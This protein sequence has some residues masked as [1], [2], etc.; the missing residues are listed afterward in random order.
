MSAFGIYGSRVWRVFRLVEE[1]FSVCVPKV[2]IAFETRL[3]TGERYFYVYV[4]H[5]GLRGTNNSKTEGDSADM[6]V[7]PN[8]YRT[9]KT[10]NPEFLNPS[11]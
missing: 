3:M 1:M 2:M 11:P 5:A 4:A 9:T 7:P 10:L 6:S 8:P